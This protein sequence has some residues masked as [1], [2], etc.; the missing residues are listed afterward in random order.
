LRQ[1]AQNPVD[2]HEW[3]DEA[4]AR[5]RAENRPVLLSV[6]YSACH[7]CHVM[8]HESFED[9]ATAA[10]MNELYVSVKVD[11]EERPD[12][13]AVYQKVVQLM[14]QG[15]GWPLT[16]FLTPDQ[17]PFYG[18]TYF[19]P[20]PSHGRPGFSQVL[21]AVHEAFAR[22]PADVAE[23]AGAFQRG[24]A[25]IAGALD[26]GE[27]VA[28]PSL[29]DRHTFVRAGRR[30]LARVDE[31]WGG[32]GDAPK[33]PS[34]TGLELLLALAR[35]HD[36]GTLAEDAAQ[37][38]DT[39]LERMWRG[40]IYDHLR[41]G[42]A[43]YSVDRVWLV[44]HFEK[45][46]Y[47]S[48]QLVGLYA[49]AAALWPER[50][51]LP[52]VVEETIAYLVADMR[53]HAGTFYAATDADSEGIEGKYF[54]WT[55]AQVH[56]ALSDTETSER[57]CRVYGVT[58][59]GNFE[60]GSILHLARSFEECAADVGMDLED[61]R[62]EL[63]RA[64]HRLLEARTTRVPPHRDDKI[65]TAWNALLVSGLCRAA[66]AAPS[67]KRPATASAVRWTGLARELVDELLA[68]HVDPDGRVLRAAFEG[69]VHTRGVI[70]DVAFLARACL[71]LHGL[72]LEPRYLDSARALATRGLADHGREG[73]G[74]FLT[75]NDGE[76]LI[77]RSESLHDTA[78]P[79]GAAIMVE[80]L[81]RLDLA[82][83]APEGGRAAAEATLARHA[84]AASEP[85]LVA[86]ML[87]A[88]AFAG[89]AVP[90][91]TVHGPAPEDPAVQELAGT[92]HALRLRAPAPV[93]L[94]YERDDR[95]GAVVCR[96]ETC[97]TLLRTAA[98]VR[99]ELTD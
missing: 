92:V 70:D 63:D 87:S 38:L 61:L 35:M 67:W 5:A 89:P 50:D 86:S 62:S 53:T 96:A 6:G 69:H 18:G 54:V 20:E 97:S 12:I 68:R 94:S 95:V 30:L 3:G 71:D 16:V 13:D 27:R 33:F 59:D 11:R 47:D 98:E 49:E 21:R 24:L 29:A 79:A 45:M 43:R 52:R 99:R 77:E 10:L 56:E 44:P 72:T 85:L 26:R 88:A 73:G 31:T 28:H 51:H 39:T 36:E 64:R 80:V 66:A 91:V 1:H 55:P 46:L 40:G 58:E 42:F 8:A 4:F 82:G 65:I 81:L 15:G 37:A 60:G 75:P 22:R 76:Q 32:F 7:W 19:P 17:L 84:V 25:E 14:G 93:T 9:P 78:I 83:V 2:W 23:Q 90:H 41:G 48:A 34:P 57:F 74:F